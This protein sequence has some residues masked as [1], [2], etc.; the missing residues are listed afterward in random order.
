MASLLPS[1]PSPADYRR[2][3]ADRSVW[4]SALTAICAR[5]DLDANNLERQPAGT[6]VVF[7]TGSHI[8]KLYAPFWLED[9]TAERAALRPLRGLPTPE[10]VAQGEIEGWPYLVMTIVPGRPA[11]EIWPNLTGT[12]RIDIARLLGKLMRQL[13]RQGPVTE[14]AIDWDVFLGERVSGAEEFH[15]AGESWHDWIR[16]Q[17]ADFH[18]PPFSPVLLHADITADHVLL[19]R[20][21]QG[22]RITGLIDFGDAMMGHP[23]YEFIAPLAFYCFG[24]PPASRALLEGYGLDLTPEVADRLTTYCLLHKFGRIGVFLARHA[25]ADGAAFHRALWG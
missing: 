13:H 1:L 7:R 23:F 10:L 21:A 3:H 22:W 17:L 2:V 16:E 12:E 6:H 4:L 5:H 8:V 15:A 19:S 24:D 25:A 11:E 18:D 9:F 20:T 14:L